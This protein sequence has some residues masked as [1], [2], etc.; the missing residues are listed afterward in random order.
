MEQALI[1]ASAI[2]FN[3]ENY[4]SATDYYEKLEKIAF[5]SRVKI[6][7]LRG[8]LRS[9]YQ[10]GDATRTI[11]A[12]ERIGNTRDIPDELRREATFMKGKA[13]YSLNEYDTAL[14]EFRKVANGGSAEGAESKYRVA[15]LYR[16]A[17][18]LNRRGCNPVYRPELSASVLDG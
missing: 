3:N 6:V 18:L 17:I 8:L 7:A 10:S 15:E 11:S 14:E 5:S 9:A 13:H 12:S 2:E 1:S 4:T 16:K